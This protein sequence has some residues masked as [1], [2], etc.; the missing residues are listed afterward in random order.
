MLL[1]AEADY[2]NARSKF[3]PSPRINLT[4]NARGAFEVIS[5]CDMSAIDI[6]RNVIQSQVAL[7]FLVSIAE[8]DGCNVSLR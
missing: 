2:G 1:L 4:D 6:V 7:F 5:M 8:Y 3:L